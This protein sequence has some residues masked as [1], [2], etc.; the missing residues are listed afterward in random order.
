MSDST[1][2]AAATDTATAPTPAEN[3]EEA[4]EQKRS[5]AD[6]ADE[7]SEQENAP[8]T[9]EDKAAAELDV[10]SLTIGEQ[11]KINKFLDEPEDSNIKA[12][13][14]LS[15]FSSSPYLFIP[16][17]KVAGLVNMLCSVEFI[18]Y[19]YGLFL[20]VLLDS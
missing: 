15:P 14:S 4:P 8:S 1:A 17:S 19:L 18:K 20:V 7:E 6:E 9:S 3:K 11:K 16:P 10:D 12:V 5:W 2:A 13:W